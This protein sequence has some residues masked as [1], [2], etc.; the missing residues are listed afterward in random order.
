[1]TPHGLLEPN[2]T[3]MWEGA[4][5]SKWRLPNSRV[6]QLFFGFFISIFLFLG[7]AW[8]FTAFKSNIPGYAVTALVA[9]KTWQIR[10]TAKANTAIRNSPTYIVTDKQV[11][12]PDF[13]TDHLD[14]QAISLSEL[15]EIKVL[16]KN[17]LMDIIFC[18][19]N[20][21]KYEPRARAGSRK[22]YITFTFGFKGVEK[23]LSPIFVIQEALE[24][25]SETNAYFTFT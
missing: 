15:E 6:R 25:T 1:M 21:E 23:D 12:F 4:P 10:Q 14:H 9:L 2:E 16:E 24:N 22:K 17:G 11:I 7:L 3:V 20:R 18:V 5:S 8:V 13:F 19:E